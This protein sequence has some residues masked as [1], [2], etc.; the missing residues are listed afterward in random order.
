M[1]KKSAQTAV[2]VS[3]A[4]CFAFTAL[5][6]ITGGGLKNAGKSFIGEAF[7]FLALAAGADVA[8]GVAGPFSYLVLA[9]V[10]LTDGT[11]ALKALDNIHSPTGD[12]ANA[13]TNAQAAAVNPQSPLDTNSGGTTPSL[14]GLNGSALAALIVK[15]AKSFQGTPY[16]LGGSSPSGF[17]CSGL[18]YYLG[19]KYAG[20]T[21]PRRSQDQAKAGTAVSSILTAKPGDLLFFTISHAEGGEGTP[22][23]HEGIYLGNGMMIEAPHTGDVV[24]IAPLQ[25]FYMSH[26]TTIRRVF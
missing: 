24:K 21:L 17:D 25:G 9:T 4:G 12:K 20:I 19:Q 5:T 15:E 10:G 13:I 22:N 7:I 1:D 14:G 23:D 3:A 16:V 11:K 18:V 8:P 2:V 26:L 6:A